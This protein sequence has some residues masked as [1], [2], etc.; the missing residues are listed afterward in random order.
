MVMASLWH[1]NV[2]S[3]VE[4]QTIIGFVLEFLK[5]FGCG[6]LG[7]EIWQKV[8]GEEEAMVKGGRGRRIGVGWTVIIKN[9][10]M[11]VDEKRTWKPKG[12]K[13][14]KVDGWW[15]FLMKFSLF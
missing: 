1:L 13:D 10:L 11:D 7:R 3:F 8:L 2:V 9:D 12:E 15:L 6:V 5:K 14:K 4:W